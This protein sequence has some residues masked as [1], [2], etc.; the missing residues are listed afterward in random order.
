VRGHGNGPAVGLRADMDALA[1]TE[2]TG[3]PYQ[4]QHPDVM[5]AC[6]H[7]GHMT[8]SFWGRR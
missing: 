2:R 6:G 3:L 1:I 8:Y 7:D 4:S 5:H